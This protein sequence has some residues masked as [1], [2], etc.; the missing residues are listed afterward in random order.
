VLF[1]LIPLIVLHI[2]TNYFLT[3]KLVQAEIVLR[4]FITTFTAASASTIILAILGIPLSYILARREFRGKSIVES[5]IDIPLVIPHAVVGILILV[6]Y[7]S[8]T[9]IGNILSNLGLIVEDNFWGIV[10]VMVYVSAPLL[11][12]SVKD[13]FK[14]VDPMLEYVARTLGAGPYRTFFTISLPMAWR[15]VVTGIILSWARAVSEVGALLIVAYYPKTINI[16]IIEWF[17]T[18]G[19]E[20][21][22][23]LTVPLLV[24]C[25]VLFACIRYL[26]RRA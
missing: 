9:S 1:I 5:I 22:K 23:S 7:S 14:S 24:I 26:S 6:A 15:S 13:G 16:L 20:Y 2:A 25:I 10:F 21:A 12:D 8:R 4:A 3:Y 17:N 19:L 18:F 11:V